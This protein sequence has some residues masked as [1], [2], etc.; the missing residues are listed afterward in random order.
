M[1][2][3]RVLLSAGFAALAA[4]AISQSDIRSNEVFV[5]TV[6]S[7]SPNYTLDLVRT[8]I[9]QHRH[10]KVRFWGVS[11]RRSAKAREYLVA[12]LLHRTAAVQVFGRTGHTVLGEVSGTLPGVKS[13]PELLNLGLIYEGHAVWNKRQTAKYPVSSGLFALAEKQG[14]KFRAMRASARRKS[15]KPSP[16]GDR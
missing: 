3:S 5:G 4:Q 9:P 6:E 2:A 10:V 13:S 7:I 11:I 16:A 1:R 12:Y 8:D 14:P 15:G